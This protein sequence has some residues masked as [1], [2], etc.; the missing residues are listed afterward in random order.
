MVIIGWDVVVLEVV[1]VVFGYNVIV[2]CNEIGIVVV[3]C[4]LIC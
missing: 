1:C 2:I 3:V 4:E